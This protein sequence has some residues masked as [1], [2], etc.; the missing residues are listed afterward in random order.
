LYQQPQLLY[1]WTGFCHEMLHMSHCTNQVQIAASLCSSIKPIYIY[2]SLLC[3]LIKCLGHSPFNM[4]QLWA[5]SKLKYA[6][7]TVTGS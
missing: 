5:F 4:K 1:Q 6:C 3:S 7:H 2:Q